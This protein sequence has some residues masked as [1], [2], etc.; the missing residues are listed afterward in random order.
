MI[1][2]YDA[3]TW[4]ELP[5]PLQSHTLT[6]TKTKFSHND[7]YLLTVSR[8][9]IWSIFERC[10]EGIYYKIPFNTSFQEKILTIH[11]YVYIGTTPYKFVTKNKAHSRIIW[12]C[13]WSHNDTLFATGSRDKTVCVF[14]NIY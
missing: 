1:R 8:D 6:V 10:D 11:K 9:R 13:S 4:K 3:S 2:L 7:K 5:N 12:D 14:V